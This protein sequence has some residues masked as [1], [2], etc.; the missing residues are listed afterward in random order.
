MKTKTITTA[1]G[2]SLSYNDIITRQNKFKSK[3]AKQLK[4]DKYLNQYKLINTGSLPSISDDE[5]CNNAIKGVSVLQLQLQRSARNLAKN[6][7]GCTPY[8]FRKE[9]KVIAKTWLDQNQQEI[10]NEIIGPVLANAIKSRER[11]ENTRRR[12]EWINNNVIQQQQIPE[13]FYVIAKMPQVG[14]DFDTRKRI[15]VYDHKKNA[16]VKKPNRAVWDNPNVTRYSII[17]KLLLACDA[18]PEETGVSIID[19]KNRKEALKQALAEREVS[20]HVSYIQVDN[21][22]ETN[23]REMDA[24]MFSLVPTSNISTRYAFSDKN[25]LYKLSDEKIKFNAPI[26]GVLDNDEAVP[27]SHYELEDYAL[28]GMLDDSDSITDD[29]LEQSFNSSM[30]RGAR[31]TELAD[32]HMGI[33]AYVQLAFEIGDTDLVELATDPINPECPLTP[34]IAQSVWDGDMPAPDA[35]VL[36]GDVYYTYDQ[37]GNSIK[38]RALWLREAMD[39]LINENLIG[40]FSTPADEDAAFLAQIEVLI[41][42]YGKVALDTTPRTKTRHG[43]IK[44]VY[45]QGAQ[46]EINHNTPPEVIEQ[47]IY[48]LGF[49]ALQPHS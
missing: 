10:D 6:M 22:H 5:L 37:H 26:D 49:R 1:N 35:I 34:N 11:S 19:T 17:T 41:R 36:W 24:M 33:D 20:L 3:Q 18:L 29:S 30:A 27:I 4:E 9:L 8:Q 44:L 12:N 2:K 40:P 43:K 23:G 39:V 15:W 21:V 28:K 38:K 13:E 25:T 7:V 14:V 31:P 32:L 46:V 48:N 16:P 47:I 45:H 42:K